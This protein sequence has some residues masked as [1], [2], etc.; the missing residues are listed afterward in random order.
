MCQPLR[1][2]CLC[3]APS[4]VVGLR[5]LFTEAW[6]SRLWIVFATLFFIRAL[7][8]GGTKIGNKI[9]NKINTVLLILENIC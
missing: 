2:G 3:A 7:D 4:A 5:G 1:F 6:H 8:Q 9:S